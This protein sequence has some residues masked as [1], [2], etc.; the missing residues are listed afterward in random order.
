MRGRI[1]STQGA[2]RLDARPVV[3]F[4]N[5]IRRPNKKPSNAPTL[6]MTTLPH[7][8]QCTWLQPQRLNLY[9]HRHLGRCTGG[10]LLH[11]RHTMEVTAVICC[12][13]SHCLLAAGLGDLLSVRS[14]KNGGSLVASSSTSSTSLVA[15][16]GIFGVETAGGGPSFLFLFLSA[17]SLA[18]L[19]VSPL[20]SALVVDYFTVAAHILR[21][22]FVALLAS[23]R[24]T[25]SPPTS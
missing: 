20:T 17:S 18:V 3:F 22:G 12:S 8:C 19:A 25:T 6:S 2:L 11:Q 4:V 16:V 23:G 9:L 14:S 1:L 10:S 15:G 7:D 24:L 21:P 5:I 13:K